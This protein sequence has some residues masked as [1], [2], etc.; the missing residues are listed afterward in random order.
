MENRN[1]KRQIIIALLPISVLSTV[2][3]FS[4]GAGALAGS[5]YN[6]GYNGPS[7]QSEY[8]AEEQKPEVPSHE[9]VYISV[10]KFIVNCNPFKKETGIN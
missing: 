10:F 5:K 7:Y 9:P 1:L 6:L 2:V 4:M 8:S 3:F